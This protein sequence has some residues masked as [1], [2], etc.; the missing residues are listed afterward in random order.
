M[1]EQSVKLKYGLSE[2]FSPGGGLTGVM[3]TE[4]SA[5]VKNIAFEKDVAI[6]YAQ[7]DGTWSENHSYGKKNFGN[8]DPFS[9]NDNTF[10][11]GRFVIRYSVFGKTFWDNNNGVDYHLDSAHPNTI[12][13]N[14]LLNKIT[15]RQGLEGSP[16]VVTSWVEGEILVKNLCFNKRVGIR[17]SAGGGTTFH[18]TE[19]PF[20]DAVPVSFGVSADF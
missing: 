11:T 6:H 16:A 15:A 18:D 14:V 17:L 13:R 19:G 8:Y 20:S 9:R 4:I 3:N 12:G 5:K 1:S 10:I 2:T 7:A